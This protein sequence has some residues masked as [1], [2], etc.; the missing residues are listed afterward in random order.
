[1]ELLNHPYMGYFVYVCMVG[2]MWLGSQALEG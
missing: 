1:M 2:A